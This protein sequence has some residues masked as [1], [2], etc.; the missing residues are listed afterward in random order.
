MVDYVNIGMQTVTVMLWVFVSLMMIGLGVFAWYIMSFKNKLIIRDL[1]NNRKI[2]RTYKWKEHK[3]KKGTTWLIT[4]FKKLKKST[5][6]PEAIDINNKGRKFVEAWRS[7]EDPSTLIWVKD[8]FEYSKEKE[9]MEKNGFEPL[10]TL[11]RE[12]LIEE[13]VKAKDYE[14]T[15]LMSKILQ[16]A[17][18]MVPIILVVVIAF[19]LGDITD[20]LT[21]YA[22][23]IK[24]PMAKIS[25][26]F[27]RA[28]EN[29]AGIQNTDMTNTTLEVP[30]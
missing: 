2:V 13:L 4:P 9:E 22:S 5:P 29:M 19:T 8:S 15:D 26:A 7:S 1:V 23:S 18:F 27:E 25:E 20:A 10:T 14:G 12:L 30:N 21:E 24:E 11:E 3:D 16:I 17:T 6:P 28:S